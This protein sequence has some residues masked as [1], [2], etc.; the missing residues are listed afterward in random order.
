M[1]PVVGEI[2]KQSHSVIL[3]PESFTLDYVICSHMIWIIKVTLH[4]IAHRQRLSSKSIRK[5]TWKAGEGREVEHEISQA[6][7]DE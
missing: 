4:S 3:L 2:N 1:A 7:G 6:R 5:E